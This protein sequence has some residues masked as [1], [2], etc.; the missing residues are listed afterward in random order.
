MF[1]PSG[2]F[3]IRVRGADAVGVIVV[4]ATVGVVTLVVVVV[5]VIVVVLV[6]VGVTVHVVIISLSIKGCCVSLGHDGN[7]AYHEQPRVGSKPPRR[8]WPPVWRQPRFDQV[9][10]LYLSA[11]CVRHELSQ[12]R[13]WRF[14]A[15]LW[16]S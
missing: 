3:V 9:R 14:S 16:A 13:S 12:R 5:V 8:S 15:I 10:A 1:S 11:L 4:V 2:P 6:T 7:Y